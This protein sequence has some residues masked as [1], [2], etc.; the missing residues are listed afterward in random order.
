MIKALSEKFGEDSSST[1]VKGTIAITEEESEVQEA[2]ITL[3]TELP[4]GKVLKRKK[5]DTSK[6]SPTPP[7]VKRPNTRASAASPSKKTKSVT[8]PKVTKTYKKSTR[9]LILAKESSDTE[10][11]DASKFQIVKSKKVN[12]HSVENFCANQKEYGGFGSFKYV[13]YETKNNDEK[14]QIE[15]AVICTLLKFRLAPLE[16]AKSLPNE[17]YLHIDNRWKYAMDS[18][19]QIRERSLVHL[20]PD[21]SVAE[22]KEHLTTYNS[23]FLVK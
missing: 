5:Q 2:T 6:A 14:R 17:L 4:K 22:I 20:F 15:E 3:S 21:M 9:R 23:K 13:K 10:S 12:I 16:L 7:P 18:E 8:A 11:E 1:P 19:K